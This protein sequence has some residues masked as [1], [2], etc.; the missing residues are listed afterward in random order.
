M[1]SYRR[2]LILSCLQIPV[3]CN[4]HQMLLF[5]FS[6]L[7]KFQPKFSMDPRFASHQV[8]QMQP[9]QNQVQFPF[10]SHGPLPSVCPSIKDYL[11]EARSRIC[12]WLACLTQYWSYFWSLL[13]CLIFMSIDVPCLRSLPTLVYPF[14]C[15]RNSLCKN[16]SCHFPT[17]EIPGSEGSG[18]SHPNQTWNS[19][20]PI[21]VTLTTFPSQLYFFISLTAPRNC[22]LTLYVP[23]GKIHL[24]C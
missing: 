14:L 15:G 9:V 18:E 6:I 11:F 21:T 7:W 17:P 4:G 13:T 2:L 3:K 10:C 24:E 8:S 12:L 5:T 22:I 23:P 16:H 19:R 1:L 20:S